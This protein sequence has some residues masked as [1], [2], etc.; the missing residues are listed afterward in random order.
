MLSAG[1]LS[2]Q[3][4]SAKATSVVSYFRRCRFVREREDLVI[5]RVPYQS[6]SV[7]LCFPIP[8]SLCVWASSPAYLCL[9]RR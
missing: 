6:G 2:F 8:S 3:G 1:V 9:G 4:V 5:L 7:T